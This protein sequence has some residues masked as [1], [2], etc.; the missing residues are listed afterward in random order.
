MLLVDSLIKEVLQNK[1]LLFILK[2]LKKSIEVL[3]EVTQG[4]LFETQVK[5]VLQTFLYKGLKEVGTG[6]T[7]SIK[8]L[9]EGYLK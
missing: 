2:V 3:V 1:G 5:D 8:W 9:K 4:Y 6:H 7:K